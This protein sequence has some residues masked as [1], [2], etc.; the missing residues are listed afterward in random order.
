ME[1]LPA[2]RGRRRGPFV[3]AD[4][5]NNELVV[6]GFRA[7]ASAYFNANNYS[8]NGSL[9]VAARFVDGTAA[10]R[11]GGLSV[12]DADAYS[13]TLDSPG[14]DFGGWPAHLE[15]RATVGFGKLNLRA[16]TGAGAAAVLKAAGASDLQVVDG[17]AVAVAGSSRGGPRRRPSAGDVESAAT[18][19][20]CTACGTATRSSSR[21][22]AA[23]AA[24]G[25][26]PG[27]GLEEEHT[28]ST[29]ALAEANRALVGLQYVPDFWN[30]A[31]Q[32]ESRGRRGLRGRV[33]GDGPLE[34]ITVAAS[35]PGPLGSSTYEFY[36][37]P[38]NDAPVLASARSAHS[39][40][41]PTRRRG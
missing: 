3:S 26:R 33:D 29:T 21:R 1:P 35:A 8:G 25:A 2:N 27:R 22:G 4:D 20:A 30:S 36:V 32:A 17:D 11:V 37:K 13:P 14:V 28:W 10:V 24:D 5:E 7:G 38:V 16:G 39:R 23:G 18:A 41:R 6:G 12:D 19:T 34:T 15:V 40:A 31:A 9:V